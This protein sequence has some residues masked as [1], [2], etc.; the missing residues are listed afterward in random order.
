MYTP[1]LIYLAIRIF[2]RVAK[3]DPDNDSAKSTGV[4]LFSALVAMK[5]A[6]PVAE[7]NLFQLEAE[8]IG[9]EAFQ[10]N[11]K[12]P[13]GLEKNLV[14]SIPLSFIVSTFRI[15]DCVLI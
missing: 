7:I 14:S 12:A 2:A 1:F 10:E 6:L 5:E 3:N 15:A 13:S 4:F 11:A 8:G 9:L